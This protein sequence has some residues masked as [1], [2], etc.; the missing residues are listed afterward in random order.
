MA[1]SHCPRRPIPPVVPSPPPSH[2]P[3]ASPF[4]LASPQEDEGYPRAGHE[5]AEYSPRR[6]ILGH[7]N[8]RPDVITVQVFCLSLDP[9]LPY[10]RAH[11]S[12]IS[13]LN[14]FF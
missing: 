1:P 9:F 2:R 6:P 10:V 4:L 7:I 8:V 13:P 14:S 5:Q 3:P 11:S 12:H